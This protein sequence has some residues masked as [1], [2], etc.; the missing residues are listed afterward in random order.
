MKI[1]LE[2]ERVGDRILPYEVKAG[3]DDEGYGLNAEAR[4]YL[5]ATYLR[6][7]RDAK[8][9]LT[10]RRNS[11]LSQIL[12]AHEAFQPSTGEHDFVTA[13]KAL[14]TGIER[15]FEG[16]AAGGTPHPDQRGRVLKTRIDDYLDKFSNKKSKFQM[17]D[18]TLRSILESLCLLFNEG[19]NLGLGSHNIL[20][21]ASELLHLQKTDWSGLRLGLIEEIEAHLHPQVQL[22]VTQYQYL[23]CCDLE[24]MRI[25]ELLK[26]DIINVPGPR[27][28]CKEIVHGPVPGIDVKHSH[29]PDAPGRHD[30]E[31]DGEFQSASRFKAVLAVNDLHLLVDVYDGE[32]V[33][34]LSERIHQG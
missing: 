21:I 20:V 24:R 16:Q 33:A 9:E 18:S 8:T 23:V 1:F 17:N 28:R 5:R 22:Q 31:V 11:R 4:A 26:P 29:L 27:V 14:N 2:V 30:H 6:P 13:V 25:A 15:Y 7:L 19:V 32:Q 3:N 10:P 34:V 12:L